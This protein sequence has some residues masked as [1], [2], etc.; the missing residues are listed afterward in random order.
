[1][2]KKEMQAAIKRLTF[3]MT[4]SMSTANFCM[5]EMYLDSEN[6]LWDIARYIEK[7]VDEDI[8]Y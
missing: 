1:M 7:L 3:E 5:G 2:N 8:Y 6:D 4:A